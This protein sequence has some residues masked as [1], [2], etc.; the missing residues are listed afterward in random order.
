[1]KQKDSTM[2]DSGHWTPLYNQ[3]RVLTYLLLAN[4]YV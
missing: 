4:Y 2:L 3:K 1:M